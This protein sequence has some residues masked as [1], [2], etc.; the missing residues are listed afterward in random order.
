MNC[1]NFSSVSLTILNG[2]T[3]EISSKQE[4]KDS[5]KVFDKSSVFDSIMPDSLNNDLEDFIEDLNYGSDETRTI[6]MPIER[7]LVLFEMLRPE[8]EAN[9]QGRDRSHDYQFLKSKC[10]RLT[11]YLK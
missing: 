4:V 1:Y 9:M 8:A 10:E 2:C 6:D 5:Y 11:V 7:Q 3:Y